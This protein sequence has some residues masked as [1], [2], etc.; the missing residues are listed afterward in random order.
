MVYLDMEQSQHS[1]LDNYLALI[2]SE[3]RKSWVKDPKK[4]RQKDFL[5]VT[6]DQ[7]ERQQKSERSKSIWMAALNIKPKK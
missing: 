3:I 6:E 1:K 5:F 4:V 2:A 7:T